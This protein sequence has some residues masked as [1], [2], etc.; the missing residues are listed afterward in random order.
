[1]TGPA[2]LSRA[3]NSNR[4]TA[5]ITNASQEEIDELLATVSPLATS[6]SELVELVR[7]PHFQGALNQLDEILLQGGTQGLSAELG[8]PYEGEGV[9]SFLNAIRKQFSK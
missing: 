9:V 8:V 6:P 2:S 5:H 1:M 4:L 7:S 3:L